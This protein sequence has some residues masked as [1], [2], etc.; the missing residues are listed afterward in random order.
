MA[1]DLDELHASI[2]DVLR[3][4][5]VVRRMEDVASDLLGE[6]MGEQHIRSVG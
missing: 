3:Y 1:N 6:P 4:S 2:N 5:A